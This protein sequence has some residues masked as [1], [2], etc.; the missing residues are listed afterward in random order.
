MTQSRDRTEF[1]DFLTGLDPL[2]PTPLWQTAL[3]RTQLKRLN[4][5]TNKSCSFGIRLR[6]CIF[7]RMFFSD[8]E[9]CYATDKCK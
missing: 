8:V 9:Q 5:S 2:P 6:S 3:S 7:L 1:Q 4:V